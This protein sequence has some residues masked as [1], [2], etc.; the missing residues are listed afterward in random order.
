MTTP[1]TALLM[2]DY[3]RALCEDGPYTRL[4]SLVEQV[5][6]RGVLKNAAR[7][8]EA[9]RHA[10]LFV[11]HVRLAFDPTYQLRTNRNPRFDAYE[12]EQAMRRNSPEAE[13]VDLLAPED[14]EPV[15]DKTAVDPFV[16]TPLLPV[17]AGAGIRN[18]ILGG[19][20]TN[21]VVESA[22]R[23]GCDAGLAVTV[24]EDMCA[25]VSAEFHEFSITKMLP[26]FARVVSIDGIL[27]ELA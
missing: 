7:V 27:K 6:Q 19:V 20:A 5:E 12:N 14:E 3:Q 10:G 9:A 11:V 25:S 2:L 15:V 1:D 13:I 4:P 24:V 8:L 17:L 26:M 21:L 22:A 18:V 23:H 16:G